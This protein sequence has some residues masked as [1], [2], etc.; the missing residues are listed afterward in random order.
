MY[1]IQSLISSCLGKQQT[2][3]YLLACNIQKSKKLQKINE[4]YYILLS[5]VN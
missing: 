3:T 5:K 2:S 1:L 4:G